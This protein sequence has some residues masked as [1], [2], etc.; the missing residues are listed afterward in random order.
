M[1]KDLTDLYGV[2]LAGGSGTRLWPL[3]RDLNPKQL[4]TL[5]GTESLISQTVNRLLPLV[6][7]EHIYVVAAENLLS[8]IKIHLSHHRK[9]FKKIQF[10]P[11][12]LPK[13]T[14]PAIGLAAAYLQRAD[15][16]AVL[17]VFP[18][19]QYVEGEEKFRAT[20]SQAYFLASKGFLV[21]L[22]IKPKK[23]DTN[24]GYIRVGK[25]LSGLGFEAFNVAEFSEK[26]PL[27][28]AQR[29]VDS[30]EYYWNS[31]M[32]I[33]RAAAILKEISKYMP[34]LHRVLTE[35]VKKEV[36]EERQRILFERLEAKSID[37]GVMER[38]DKVVMI[39]AAF[40]WSDVGTLLAVEEFSE[41]DDHGNIISGNVID[42]DSVN[43][44]IQAKDRLVATIGLK[45]MLVVDTY[46]ATLICPKKRVQ[47]VRKVVEVLKKKQVD[48]FF[49]PRTVERP[50]GSHTLLEKGPDYRIKLV[51]IKPGGK[52]SHQLHHHRSEHWVIICGVAKIT[53]GQEEFS[54]RA[55]ESTFIPLSTPHRLENSGS[56]PLKLIEVQI[57]NPLGE[58]DIV[59]FEDD[60]ATD[61]A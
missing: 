10:L 59:R 58:N 6:D 34:D 29:F 20:L 60:Y 27:A 47:D 30:G 23:A 40:R 18:S 55:N 43:S 19:D 51:E 35:I 21:T 7:E 26:P 49:A 13:N 32:F 16:E 38:S 15:P 9:P 4:L 2:I 14:A 17:A 22:G 52:L 50:W 11:E 12:P 24:Y 37:Y 45:N 3:S 8:E 44:V 53:R 31:G 56:E 54:M 39:P 42:V 48:E 25:K 61:E 41:K 57:G 36:E 5:F 33:F 28:T 46:D 1:E